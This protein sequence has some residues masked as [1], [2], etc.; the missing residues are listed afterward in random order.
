MFFV[1]AFWRSCLRI[2]YLSLYLSYWSFFYE[3]RNIYKKGFLNLNDIDLEIQ[4]CGG[5]NST[6][7]E[8]VHRAK[9]IKKE[10]LS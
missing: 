6:R 10:W 2:P 8:N 7:Q 4:T 3:N 9:V 1:P 5:N